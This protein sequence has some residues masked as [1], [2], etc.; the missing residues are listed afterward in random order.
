MTRYTQVFRSLPNRRSA[1]G[2]LTAPSHPRPHGVIVLNCYGRGGSGILWRM[3]G[4]SPDVIMT[5]DEWHVGVFGDADFLRKATLLAFRFP[6]IKSFEP[7]RRYAF[8]KTM[9]MQQADDVITKLEAPFCV[10]KLMD[11]HIRFLRDDS[12]VVSANNVRQ[13]DPPSLRPVREPYAEWTWT[14]RSVSLVQR[15]RGHAS[16]AVRAGGDCRPI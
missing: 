10:I 8:N 15:R 16:G 2:G 11:Y 14:R 5:T 1:E 7:L 9:E 4:S 13:S 3:I 6:M 12:P